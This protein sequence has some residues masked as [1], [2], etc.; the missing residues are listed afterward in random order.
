[1]E[2]GGLDAGAGFGEGSRENHGVSDGQCIGGVSFGRVDVDPLKGGERSRVEPPA[3]GEQRIAPYIGYGG[4]EVETAGDRHGHYLILIRRED[5]GQLADAFGIGAR[6]LADIKSAVD[7]ENVAAFDGCWCRDGVQLA[8]RRESARQR[9]GFGLARFRAQRE[10]DGQFVKN[11]SWIFDEHG[12]GKRWLSRKRVDV[13]SEFRQQMFVSR[14]LGLGLR[15][16]DGLAFNECELALSE[17]R[18]YG[19][20]DGGQHEVILAGTVDDRRVS[21]AIAASIEGEWCC[22]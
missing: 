13:D 16:V 12:I 19:A 7:A 9:L 15:H 18:A 22:R 4:F 1:V 6:G 2:T 11:D 20:S 10:D 21:L 8:K 3:I 14:V 17:G 5:G